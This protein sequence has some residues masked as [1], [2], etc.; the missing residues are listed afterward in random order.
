MYTCG[1]NN[2]WEIV[3][4]HTYTTHAHTQAHTLEMLM[5]IDVMSKCDY[6]KNEWMNE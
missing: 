5:E 4:N 6:D 2:L 3:A 1:D